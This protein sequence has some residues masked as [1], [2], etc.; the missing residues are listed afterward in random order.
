MAQVTHRLSNEF[1]ERNLFLQVGLGLASLS[2]RV[3]RLLER[4]A[5]PARVRA[6]LDREADAFLH[7]LLGLLSVSTTVTM[8]LE[9]AAPARRPPRR[10]R[11]VRG[12]V[13]PRALLV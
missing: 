9:R 8:H 6:P 11:T 7:V 13:A 2:R 4:H 3:P 10:A 12:R 1:D 5:L